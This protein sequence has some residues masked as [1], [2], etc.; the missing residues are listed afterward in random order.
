M[1]TR[2]MRSR[3]AYFDRG[4]IDVK[5]ALAEPIKQI[6]D[7]AS[8]GTIVAAFLGWLPH[9]ATL[10]SIVWMVIRISETTTVRRLFGKDPL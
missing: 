1:R 8:I 3:S 9:V 10:L 5:N 2:A 6:I 7:G 4:N